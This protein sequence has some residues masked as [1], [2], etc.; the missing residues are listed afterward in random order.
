MMLVVQYFYYGAH[1]PLALPHGHSRLRAASSAARRKSVERP[2]S[3]YRTLSVVA[4]NVAVN[5]ALA[6]QQDAQSHARLPR[7][8]LDQSRDLSSR[9][10]SREVT[11]VEDDIDDPDLAA[12]TDSF[13]SEGGRTS[14]RKLVSWSRERYG[15][16]RPTRGGQIP[17]T[18][19]IHP[20][21]QITSHDPRRTGDAM[22]LD[23]GRPR[24]REG[25]QS[26]DDAEQEEW[27][28][29]TAASTVRTSSRASRRGAS[30]VFLGVWVLF[31]VGTLAGKRSGFSSGT[32]ASIGRVLTR[33]LP[34]VETS[35]LV[36][37][38]G[39]DIEDPSSVH[40]LGRIFAW[41]CTTLYLT[42]RLPQIWK[43]VSFI[44]LSLMISELMLIK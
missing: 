11:G 42:S 32:A 40:L 37:I 44:L 35:A 29:S 5:A 2:H 15:S 14:R 4:A 34:A 12:M 8:S 9:R 20:S 31:G 6:A 16:G 41:L 28:Q 19:P 43:N 21:L 1:K 13:H 27:N 26:D 30:L 18:S 33:R 25:D 36:T 17:P 7:R 23:R 22:I 3:H 24:Q 10:F 38:F 39:Q